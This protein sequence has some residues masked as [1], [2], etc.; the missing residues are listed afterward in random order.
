M[1][2]HA[3][4]KTKPDGSVADEHEWQPLAEHLNNVAELAARFARPLRMEQEAH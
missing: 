4:T 1:T 3:H 2:Y